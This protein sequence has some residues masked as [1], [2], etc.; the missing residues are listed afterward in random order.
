[1]MFPLECRL[2]HSDD[3]GI[4][5]PNGTGKYID[6]P[7]E[8][9]V[10]LKL[11]VELNPLFGPY[12]ECNPEPDTGIFRCDPRLVGDGNGTHCVCSPSRPDCGCTNMKHRAVGRDH[13]SSGGN[14]GSGQTCI[15][16]NQSQ[17]DSMCFCRWNK[18]DRQCAP[19]DCANN[20]EQAACIKEGCNGDHMC[21][22][23]PKGNGQVVLHRSEGSCVDVV[24]HTQST[25]AL[26]EGSFGCS[27]NTDSQSCLQ[28]G[29]GGTIVDR[30]RADLD[31]AI[32][33]HWFSTQALSEAVPSHSKQRSRAGGS[34]TISGVATWRIASVDA[35]KKASCVNDAMTYQI[36]SRNASCFAGCP[37]GVTNSTSDCYI[38]CLFDG[39]LGSQ[40]TGSLPLGGSLN[41]TG[42][43][44]LSA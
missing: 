9:I 3:N 29:F 36:H 19:W 5:C 41:A 26:C 14:G 1:M 42:K 27:W 30:W 13:I 39:L 32:S 25:Q 44:L 28:G 15:E 2:A 33:G 43:L 40:S 10:Y 20:T 11:T 22:W 21:Q 34:N 31:T 23:H 37:G 24:C 4:G 17:C 16:H 18:H 8:T 6:N 38:R 12:A 35:V 7:N